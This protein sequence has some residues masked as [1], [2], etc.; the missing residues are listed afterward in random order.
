MVRVKAVLTKRA[1]RG[2]EWNRVVANKP[3]INVTRRGDQ[4][5]VIRDGASHARGIYDTQAEAIE[6]GR[7]RAQTDQTELRIQG[8]DGRWRDSDSYGRDPAPPIDRKH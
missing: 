6:H 7:A 8:R 4:W 1:P 2:A 5:A 3:A